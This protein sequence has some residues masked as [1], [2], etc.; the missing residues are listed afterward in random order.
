MTL[1][2]LVIV[3]WCASGLRSTSTLR[4]TLLLAPIVVLVPVVVVAASGVGQS[5]LNLEGRVTEFYLHIKRLQVS[6]ISFT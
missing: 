1:H 4:R 6:N 3:L 5:T 2:H